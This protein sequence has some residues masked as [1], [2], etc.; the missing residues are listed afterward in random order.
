MIGSHFHRQA[1]AALNYIT[2]TVALISGFAIVK[3]DSEVIGTAV[4]I[5]IGGFLFYSSITWIG[6]RMLDRIVERQEMSEMSSRNEKDELKN[7][8]IM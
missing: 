5:I 8:S 4:G 1:L 7:V 2:D 6:G 3:L